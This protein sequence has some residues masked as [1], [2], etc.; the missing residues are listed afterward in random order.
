MR[1][2]I[3]ALTEALTGHFDA[4]HGQL[5]QSMLARIEAIESALA[6]LNAVVAT[7]FEPW[8]HPAAA[9]A[10][11]PRGGGEGRAGDHR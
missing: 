7:A 1:R 3:P 4:G 2:R 10:D 5:V 6:Q 9:A 8:A 11:H